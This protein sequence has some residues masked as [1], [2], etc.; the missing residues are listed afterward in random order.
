M[1]H[2]ERRERLNKLLKEIRSENKELTRHNAELKAHLN[3]GQAE[4]EMTDA[5]MRA[6]R[7]MG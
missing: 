6:L 3:R 1:I 2:K 4:S 7:H 5:Q